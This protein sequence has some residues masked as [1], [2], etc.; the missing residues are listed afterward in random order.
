MAVIMSE[1]IENLK[2]LNNK[3]GQGIVEFSLLCA[4]C[5]AIAI[6]MRDAGFSEAFNG[7]LEKSKPELYSAA[8]ALRPRNN[9]MEFFHKWSHKMSGTIK[10]E[11]P[12][13]DERILADQKALVKIAETF[14]GKTDNQIMILMDYYSNSDDVNKTPEYIGALACPSSGT[15]FSEGVLCP[16]SYKN[17]ILD[18]NG[19]TDNPRMDGWMHFERNNNQN[20]T[21]YLTDNEAKT[22]DKYDK[23]TNPAWKKT[24]KLSTV[25]TDRLFYSDDML[26]NAGGRV[27][28]RL[29]YTDGKVDFVDVALRVGNPDPNDG[30][31]WVTDNDSFASDLC[32]HVVQSGY[33]QID[34][35]E[36]TAGDGDI[37]NSPDNFYN[38]DGTL[39]H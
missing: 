16:L 33:T 35:T 39:I 18:K 17:N 13:N 11:E 5:A 24:S 38:T 8:I 2:R 15:G 29:H 23:D 21:Q 20:T 12:D 30:K 7:A 6:F 19:D 31:K 27:T 1:F 37:I 22:Y 3:K 10:S 26:E 28:V 4:F 25:T 36:M 9:Y 32:L 34:T 14:L